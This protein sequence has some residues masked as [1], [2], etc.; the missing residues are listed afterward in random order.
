VAPQPIWWHD[1]TI[2]VIARVVLLNLFA[3]IGL[4]LAEGL[5]ASLIDGHTPVWGTVGKAC[6]TFGMLVTELVSFRIL[7]SEEVVSR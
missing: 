3:I 2:I 4:M 6:F 7:R 1:L 5:A